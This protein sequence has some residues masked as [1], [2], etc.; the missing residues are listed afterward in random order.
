MKIGQDSAVAFDYVLRNDAGEVLDES[1]DEPLYYLHGHGNIV[2]G[3]ERALLGKAAGDTVLAVIA[4]EDGYGPAST[5]RPVRVT[6][7]RL[8]PDADIE[9][10]MPFEA[11]APDG[12]AVVLWVV[13]LDDDAVYLSPDHP[14]AG[15]TLHFDVTVREVRAATPDELA[16]GH[17]HGP[18]GAHP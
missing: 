6:R 13:D 2:P 3:L 11:V 4:P 8:P 15:V 7:D 9:P 5:A 18:G 17:V 14:L 1:G 12:N 16:H 10:G